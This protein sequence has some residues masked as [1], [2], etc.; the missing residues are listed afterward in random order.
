MIVH[1]YKRLER[2]LKSS[3]ENFEREKDAANRLRVEVTQLR[4]NRKKERET[5][6]VCSGE[7]SSVLEL[8]FNIERRSNEKESNGQSIEGFTRHSYKAKA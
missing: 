2:E 5:W 7:H 6:D 4:D 3:R 8:R 1:S